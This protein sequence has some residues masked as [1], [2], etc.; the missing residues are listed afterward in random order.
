MMKQSIYM[1]TIHIIAKKVF[2]Y[3]KH[4]VFKIETS[5]TSQDQQVP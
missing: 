4:R 3:P 1:G 2:K 5:L